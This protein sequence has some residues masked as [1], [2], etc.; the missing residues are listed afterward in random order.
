MTN[1]VC[2]FHRNSC[3]FSDTR[4]QAYKLKSKILINKYL[5]STVS[6]CHKKKLISTM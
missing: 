4:A 1:N 5:K 2:K 6:Q 3:T